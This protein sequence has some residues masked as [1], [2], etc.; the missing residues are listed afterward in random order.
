M[1]PVGPMIRVGPVGLVWRDGVVNFR[2]GHR[3]DRWRVTSG[4]CFTVPNSSRSSSLNGEA[5]PSS[6][7]PLRAAPHHGRFRTV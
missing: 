6:P 5:A 7:H 3:P 4:R 1:I 2:A